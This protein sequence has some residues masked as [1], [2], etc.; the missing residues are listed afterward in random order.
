MP[1]VRLNHRKLPILLPLLTY[2]NN[3]FIW[4]NLIWFSFVSFFLP[5]Y[6]PKNLQVLFPG[7]AVGSILWLTIKL[8]L[9]SF[10]YHER[11]LAL[12]SVSKISSLEGTIRF[13]QS[14]NIAINPKVLLY[15][16]SAWC[17]LLLVKAWKINSS[18]LPPHSK[19]TSP[20]IGFSML[21]INISWKMIQLSLF[22][23]RFRHG[24][25]ILSPR[26]MLCLDL[27]HP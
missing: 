19:W 4:L 5:S 11:L 7:L 23:G 20:M 25:S 13:N 3:S 2:K 14:S 15:W 22:L 16:A 6:P 18:V 27:Y 21:H 17:P 10:P 1:D 8:A 26:G 9:F 24:S 12:S